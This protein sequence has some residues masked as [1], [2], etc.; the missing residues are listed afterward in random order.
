MISKACL[1]GV[2]LCSSAI[3]NC[4]TRHQKISSS[5]NKITQKSLTWQH[6]GLSFLTF[7]G[8]LI[9]IKLEKTE[10]TK[11]EGGKKEEGKSSAR[12]EKKRSRVLVSPLARAE[13]DPQLPSV[14]LELKSSQVSSSQSAGSQLSP[15]AKA[16]KMRRVF[17]GICM[18][19]LSRIVAGGVKVAA[20]RRRTRGGGGQQR[21]F[22]PCPGC[23][24]FCRDKRQKIL[25]AF[26]ILSYL[27]Y[28][29][30]C[31]VVVVVKP[32]ADSLFSL[33]IFFFFLSFSGFLLSFP[34]LSLILLL[35]LMLLGLVKTHCLQWHCDDD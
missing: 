29:T 22:L 18:Q 26:F 15:G 35:L 8:I 21:P 13:L 25:L 32:A 30:F 20:P 12:F 24:S 2:T 10:A 27:P 14:S 28:R 1:L 19:H 33:L 4:E 3:F 11:S 31:Y 23:S 9:L 7:D 6:K 17:C 5:D 34:H 16:Q